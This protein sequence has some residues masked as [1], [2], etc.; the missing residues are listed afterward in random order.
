[1]DPDIIEAFKEIAAE[2]TEHHGTAVI[3][4]VVPQ[5]MLT[6]YTTKIRAVW[7]IRG[8]NH[9][10]SIEQSLSN[11]HYEISVWSHAGLINSIILRFAVPQ[12]VRHMLAMSAQLVGL[13]HENKSA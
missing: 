5:R 6:Q 10:I 4:Q 9:S 11:G 12:D 2:I 7:L 13:L 1:M 8:I 3:Y